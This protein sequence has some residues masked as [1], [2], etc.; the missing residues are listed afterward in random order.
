MRRTVGLAVVA[1]FAASGCGAGASSRVKPQTMRPGP[2]TEKRT[3]D[4]GVS[5]RRGTCH[6]I[7]TAHGRSGPI[8][9]FVGVCPS[10]G[11]PRTAYEATRQAADAIAAVDGRGVSRAATV[12]A[13]QRVSGGDRESGLEHWFIRMGREPEDVTLEGSLEV[14]QQRG[15]PDCTF[16]LYGSIIVLRR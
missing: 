7:Y 4:T 1:V 2:W 6:L 5:V 14:V 8:G 16:W 9:R 13:G 3:I 15:S 11:T 12:V 10:R